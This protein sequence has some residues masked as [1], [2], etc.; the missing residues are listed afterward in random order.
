MSGGAPIDAAPPGAVNGPGDFFD[1]ARLRL[2]LDVPAALND[3]SAPAVRGD[4]DLD[5][6][7]W[8]T[9]G[10]AAVRPAAVLV[11][12]VDRPVPVVILTQR[13]ADLASHAGQIAFPGGKIEPGDAS[14][15][16]A[17]LREAEEEIGLAQNL[18]EPIGYLD[19]YLTF[20]GFRILPTLARIAPGYALTLN[21]SEVAEAFE[22]PIEFLMQPDNY[23]RR[24]RDWNGITRHY[25]A[26]PYQDH[27]IWGVTA[28]I[29][30]NLY[31]RV[32]RG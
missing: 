5:P 13:T 25:Y 11:A 22:V 26:I 30:R 16:G 1:R 19:L 27:Y 28:G 31:E 9:A 23:Q 20:S 15:A 4:L 8:K 18:I 10:V 12:V 6:Q 17:A 21:R 32:G 14:P 7:A 2:S 29:L 24:S 3:L